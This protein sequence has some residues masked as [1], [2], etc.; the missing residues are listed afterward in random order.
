MGLCCAKDRKEREIHLKKVDEIFTRYD[1]NKN[2]ELEV[3]ELTNFLRDAFPG[4]QLTDEE[5]AT[6]SAEFDADQNGTIGL[7]EL[8]AF[9]R[10]YDAEHS[11]MQRKSALVVI[12]VQNDFIDGSLAN[13]YNAEQIVPII[14][15]IRDD[16]DL[17]VISYDW[18]PEEHCSFVESANA[19]HVALQEKDQ[20]GKFEKFQTVTL[21]DDPDRA[22][23]AQTL[24]PRHAVMDAEGA[25]CHKDLV[26]KSTD[27]A[28]YKG[29]KPNIDSYS[30][31][32]D[33]CKANDTGLRLMLEENQ[34]TDV[35]C[36]GLVFDICVKSSALHGAE[37]G[38][39]VSVIEA[40]WLGC[41][42]PPF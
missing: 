7:N 24:Y 10:C 11:V 19:G 29:V 6:L 35:Y 38:F 12:D 31:F 33:N 34:V 16:F 30:A 22:G 28:V 21:L 23:H 15:Q 17:V 40:A 18:H 25:K 4:S 41:L 3:Q 8:R 9:L 14:N 39:R 26:L 1:E 37:L 36:C 2:G 13:E 27:L 42:S 5:V 20:V 32:F